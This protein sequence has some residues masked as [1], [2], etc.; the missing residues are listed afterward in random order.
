M[1]DIDESEGKDRVLKEKKEK[2]WRRFLTAM[3]IGI[4]A[5][6]MFGTP[7]SAAS[8]DKT[9]EHEIAQDQAGDELARQQQGKHTEQAV[10]ADRVTVPVTDV[11]IESS[12][13]LSEAAVEKLL[14]ALRNDQ[15]N[16][17]ELSKEIQLVNDTGAAK[18]NATFVS[19]HDNTFRVKVANEARD[20]DRV[21][22]TVANTG[23]DY[24]GDWR[25]T[26]SYINNNI[27][28]RA[29]TLGVAYVTSPD[30]HFDDVKQ[31]AVSYR[32]LLPYAGDALTFSYSYSNVDNGNIS[33]SAYRSF[34]DYQAAGLGQ[35]VGLRYQHYLAY[36]S[37]EKD[38]LTA[39]LDYRYSKITSS[40]SMAGQT[41]NNP[42]QSYDMM[43]ASL[44]FEHN[45]RDLYHSFSY[46]VG[47]TTNLGGDDDDYEMVAPGSKQHFTFG[48]ADVN[49]Q[50]RSKSDWLLN[51][52][53]RGQYTDD[54]MPILA[55]LGAG[56]MY[57]VRG[58]A[59][60][61]ASADKG[62]IGNLEL[63]TPEVAPNLRFLA[64]LD[65]GNLTNNTSGKHYEDL[66]ST[67]L[68]LRYTDAK[69]HIALAVDYAK[70]INDVSDET[71]V[72]SAPHA[73]HRRWNVSFSISF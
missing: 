53:L 19:N 32:T 47:V 9:T 27:S 44:G 33:P 38:A 11:T 54:H 8:T 15:V 10:R 42:D 55:Q 26:L 60:T 24:T 69:N 1:G 35:N 20:N 71:L 31:A 18:L 51:T 6:T 61:I 46:Q 5:A 66:A 30:E 16:I 49:Y 63:Y 59:G 3:L 58:F 28:K 57:T 41:I 43:L 4:G 2:G 45:N 65:Y 34:L 21:T 17:H 72:S 13:S 36:T 62:F 23:N 68:G 73:N 25:T 37:R 14:P 50:L 48:S 64:F 22:L 12:S 7:V 52:R 39:A 40:L 70:I 29:D 56:G 67:G